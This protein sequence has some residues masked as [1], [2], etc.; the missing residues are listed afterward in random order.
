MHF[1]SRYLKTLE[2]WRF[3]E[4]FSDPIYKYRLWI[5]DNMGLKGLEHVCYV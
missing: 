3:H 1:Q 2:T 4:F 5:A